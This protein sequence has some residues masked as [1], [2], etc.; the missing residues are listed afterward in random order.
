MTFR[1]FSHE[2]NPGSDFVGSARVV[3]VLRPKGVQSHAEVLWTNHMADI[4]NFVLQNLTL[5]L[6]LDLFLSWLKAVTDI[7][8]VC[9]VVI[10]AN[11]PME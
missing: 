2:C 4:A 6:S 3:H 9:L 7:L 5:S 10:L 1:V 11:T 8:G